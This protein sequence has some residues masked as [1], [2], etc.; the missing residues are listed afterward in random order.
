[1]CQALQESAR[2]VARNNFLACVVSNSPYL[3]AYETSR[4]HAGADGAQ[5]LLLEYT[6]PTNLHNSSS[7]RAGVCQDDRRSWVFSDIARDGADMYS[8]HVSGEVPE[9]TRSAGGWFLLVSIGSLPP[10]DASS[11]A[12][13]RIEKARSQGA[14]HLSTNVQIREQEGQC[15]DAVDGPTD[16]EFQDTWLSSQVMRDRST[17]RCREHDLTFCDSSFASGRQLDECLVCG[18][19]CF[20]PHCSAD[21]GG[22]AST[23]ASAQ[24]KDMLRVRYAGE[25]SAPPL[26]WAME[27]TETRL[28]GATMLTEPGGGRCSKQFDFGRAVPSDE[29]CPPGSSSEQD[30]LCEKLYCA[31]VSGVEMCRGRKESYRAHTS[32]LHLRNGDTFV[33]QDHALLLEPLDHPGIFQLTIELLEI[34][35]VQSPPVQTPKSVGTERPIKPL[36]QQG[37]LEL[38]HLSAQ[39][40]STLKLESEASERRMRMVGSVQQLQAA[41]RI[42]AVTAQQPEEPRPSSDLPAAPQIV[43]RFWLHQRDAEGNA[44]TE[45]TRDMQRVSGDE[46]KSPWT[47]FPECDILMFP[48]DIS[49]IVSPR[50]PDLRH[51]ERPR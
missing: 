8:F 3:E 7:A 12:T 47:S 15:S 40:R 18:G 50:D 34:P 33:F 26:P 45:F 31:L 4:V 41:L 16:T 24:G 32:S 43:L 28:S 23:H 20:L 48:T 14:W 25:F 39:D 29:A 11:T 30:L 6:G 37:R 36:A 42:L 19:D 10:A 2:R 13:S 21:L 17:D 1:V 44:V 35:V 27:N 49:I 9:L 51:V 22:C 5:Q 46:C 38:P